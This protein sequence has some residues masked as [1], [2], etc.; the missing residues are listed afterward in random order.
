MRNDLKPG[1][2]LDDLLRL[3]RAERP[4]AA[5]W[6][7]FESELR[8]KQ[9]AAIMERPPVFGRVGDFFR[10]TLRHP[11]PLGAA[12]ALI[13]ACVGVREWHSPRARGPAAYGRGEQ[14]VAVA[15]LPAAVLSE[16]AFRTVAA[17]ALSPDA[18]R[19]LAQTVSD[20]TSGAPRAGSPRPADDSAAE[21]AA[22]RILTGE[23]A[24]SHAPEPA[25]VRNL[26]A[27]PEPAATQPWAQ[28]ASLAMVH[29]ER[30]EPLARMQVPADAV[31]TR[32]L[33]DDLPTSVSASIAS[34][35]LSD[36]RLSG[37]SD[38]RL[39]QTVRRYGVEG[40]HLLIRF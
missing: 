5:F 32:L 25:W 39:Y 9:L 31:R 4:D 13:V 33:D 40:D 21:V 15:A 19:A 28:T 30:Q 17:P 12:G 29:E 34:S 27:A 16:P 1:V 8:V 38:E 18:G 22:V 26:F 6:A 23:A 24:V 2:P 20:R 3:K 10:A 7:Q 14:A 11:I 36:H 35:V 37:L